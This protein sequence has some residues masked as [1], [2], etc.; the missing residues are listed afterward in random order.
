MDSLSIESAD[1][2]HNNIS[3]LRKLF[4][5]TILDDGK[6]DFDALRILLE[7]NSAVSTDTERYSL[8]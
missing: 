5:E 1:L 6:V 8:Q 2:I 4:P 7:K 3:Q